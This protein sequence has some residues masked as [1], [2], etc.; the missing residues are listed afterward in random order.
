MSAV[1]PGRL[2]LA[3]FVTLSLTDFLL[4]WYLLEQRGGRFYESNPVARW[5]LVQFGWAGLAAFK[6]AVVLL[7]VGVALLVSRRRPRT[8]RRVLTFGCLTTGVVVLYS[9]FLLNR[10]SASRFIPDEASILATGRQLDAKLHRSREYRAL[11]DRL[12]AHLRAGACTLEEAV[13]LLAASAQGQDPEWMRWLR[14]HYP[15]HTDRECLTAN[16]QHYAGPQLSQESQPTPA[17]P[18]SSREAPDEG[19]FVDKDPEGCRW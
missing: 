6:T 5:F 2:L 19:F 7:V 14:S 10:A 4:T 8:S 3:L 9:C 13:D 15:D 17:L 16:L 1:R 12:G 11:L 18:A